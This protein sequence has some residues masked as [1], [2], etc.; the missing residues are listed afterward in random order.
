MMFQKQG[1]QG[2][3]WMFPS[4]TETSMLGKKGEGKRRKPVFQEQLPD[5]MYEALID[6]FVEGKYFNC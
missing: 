3:C 1:S 4:L 2:N 6:I 5:T